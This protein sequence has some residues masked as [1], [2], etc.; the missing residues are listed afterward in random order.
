MKKVIVK[1]LTLLL[2]ILTV[3]SLV[4]CNGA[5]EQSG[6]VN[7]SEI[8]KAEGK[9]TFS[10]PAKT[11]TT[12]AAADAFISAFNDKYPNV[13]V[14]KDYAYEEAHFANRISAGDIGDV[15]YMAESAVYTNAVKHNALMDLSYYITAFRIDRTDIYQGIYAAGQIGEG[16]YYVARDFNQMIM[17]YNK[18][19]VDGSG[20]SEYVKEDWTW[21]DFLEYVA[22]AL[23]NDQYY[24]ASIDLSYDPVYVPMLS[25]EV[26]KNKWFDTVA[27]KV[28]LTGNDTA[29][30][31]GK[32]VEKHK[33]GEI[34][35][36]LGNRDAFAGKEAVFTQGVYLG[37]EKLGQAYDMDFIP[38][39]MMNLPLVANTDENPNKQYNS[40][41]GC[42]SSGY[43]VYKRTKNP[44]AAAAFALFFYE[45]AGQTAFN[46]QTGG[47]VP[48]LS[49]LK[50]A[51]FWQHTNDVEH[52]WNE[53]NWGANTYMAE[54]FAVIGQLQCLFPTEVADK[55][56]ST[57]KENLAY[58]VN[59]EMDLDDAM[60]KIET[61]VNQTW[62]NLKK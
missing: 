26:G 61:I 44:N 31:I 59:N 50:D 51:D 4:A 41:F 2:A 23:T 54:Q 17:I 10:Y 62:D 46:G 20:V 13:K 9:I 58:V 30:L 3:F 7:T 1:S 49:S 43:G 29:S 25:A 53:K 6:I 42:G 55:F 27:G 48:V 14:E 5:K 32:L 8:P 28:Y 40:A 16:L 18:D 36:G 12:R 56:E 47:S 21:D 22:P 57:W 60:Q 33:L 11:D 52:E 37:A 39:D 34:N 38:W 19:A 45:P 15:F 24:A 35:V